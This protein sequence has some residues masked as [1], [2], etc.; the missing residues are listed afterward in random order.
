MTICWTDKSFGDGVSK[1]LTLQ[2]VELEEV[3]FLTHKPKLQYRFLLDTSIRYLGKKNEIKY[4]DLN[5]IHGL[6]FMPR[7][8]TNY[9]HKEK[10]DKT[11]FEVITRY[12]DPVQTVMAIRTNLSLYSSIIS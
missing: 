4:T 7:R 3:V 9:V 8:P 5:A 6:C 1:Q 2:C 12:N 10:F 11:V